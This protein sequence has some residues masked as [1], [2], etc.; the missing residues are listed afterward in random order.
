MLFLHQF[1]MRFFYIALNS[2]KFRIVLNSYHSVFILLVLK[3]QQFLAV[4]RTGHPPALYTYKQYS[5]Y[6]IKGLAAAFLCSFGVQKALA[7]GAS[8]L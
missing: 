2:D 4:I 7:S 5:N 6:I 8:L 1:Y 3:L